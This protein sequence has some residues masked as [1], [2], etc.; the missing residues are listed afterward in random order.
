MKGGDD[1]SPSLGAEL[2]RVVGAAPGSV[3]DWRVAARL[4]DDL[5]AEMAGRILRAAVADLRDAVSRYVAAAR[6]GETEPARSAAHVLSSV[7]D[8]IGA[9]ALATMAR[10]A[11]V[12]A[13]AGLPAAPGAEELERLVEAAATE[14]EHHL[15]SGATD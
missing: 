4:R 10:E 5:G 11:E 2:G 14:V 12:T 15:R 7:A 13:H 8:V 1:P 3:V 6:A 9:G